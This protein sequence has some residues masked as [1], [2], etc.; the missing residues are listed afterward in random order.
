MRLLRTFSLTLF[1]GCKVEM[2]YLNVEAVNTHRDRPLVSQLSLSVS[3][4]LYCYCTSQLCACDSFNLFPLRSF[5]II[6]WGTHAA[7]PSTSMRLWMA[8]FFFTAL[9]PVYLLPLLFFST[10]FELPSVQW[11]LCGLSLMVGRCVLVL[12]TFKTLKISLV[13]RLK[14]YKPPYC[15]ARSV[16]IWTVTAVDLK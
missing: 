7:S 4:A 2:F 13:A 11:S 5:R 10:R 1:S 8:F 16:S 6:A 15:T 12:A 3:A 14:Y 9:L